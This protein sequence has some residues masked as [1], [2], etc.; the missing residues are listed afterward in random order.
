MA[1]RSR[2][3]FGRAHP[4]SRNRFFLYGPLKGK[5]MGKPNGFKKMAYTLEVF[6][7]SVLMIQ[8]VF[9]IIMKFECVREILGD[10]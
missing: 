3:E 7:L 5:T 2:G 6:S 1:P 9:I 10:L 4:R 8:V